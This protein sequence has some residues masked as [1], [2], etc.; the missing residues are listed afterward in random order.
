MNPLVVLLGG[1]LL[2][3]LLAGSSSETV[4]TGSCSW[5][6]EVGASHLQ[7]VN[8]QIKRFN[9]LADDCKKA[10]AKVEKLKP[11]EFKSYADDINSVIYEFNSA[12]NGNF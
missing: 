7:A 10:L 6:D 1:A 5:C 12:L 11:I 4:K 3:G 9:S 8:E 2:V